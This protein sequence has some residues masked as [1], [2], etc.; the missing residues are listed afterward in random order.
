M[1]LDKINKQLEEHQLFRR[2]VLLYVC[3]L[4]WYTTVESFKYASL[5][6][7]NSGIETAAIIAAIQVPV[8]AMMTMVSKFYWDGKNNG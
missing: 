1:I 2:F 7:G 8:T 3:L 5:A 4:L 6:L